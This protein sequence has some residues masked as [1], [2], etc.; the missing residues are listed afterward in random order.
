MG[1]QCECLSKEGGYR[2]TDGT[3]QPRKKRGRNKAA[4]SADVINL[5]QFG[6]YVPSLKSSDTVIPNPGLNDGKSETQLSVRPDINVLDLHYNDEV[7]NERLTAELGTNSYVKEPSKVEMVFESSSNETRAKA[8][9]ERQS[10]SRKRLTGVSTSEVAN[11]QSEESAK[12][13]E[14]HLNYLMEHISSESNN[15]E[16]RESRYSFSKRLDRVTE[17]LSSDEFI[18]RVS[19]LLSKDHPQRKK[20]KTIFRSVS[21]LHKHRVMQDENLRTSLAKQILAREDTENTSFK[22]DRAVLDYII[23]AL[24]NNQELS[25]DILK[26]FP[27]LTLRG[28]E[29]ESQEESKNGTIILPYS[30]RGSMLQDESFLHIQR[31]SEVSHV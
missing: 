17:T 10:E 8:E 19:Q 26:N 31:V 16:E 24:S 25:D 1:N 15:V 29:A 28:S 27:Q 13:G 7:G 22:D 5:S 3:P 21:S 14:D 30:E 6:S 18:A 12:I 23:N 11:L 20:M 4:T 2:S 9:S